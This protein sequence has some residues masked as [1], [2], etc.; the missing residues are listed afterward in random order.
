MTPLDDVGERLAA[1]WERVEGLRNQIIAV[2]DEN[3][4]CIAKVD[5]LRAKIDEDRERQRLERRADW[6]WRIIVGLTCVS[7]IISALAIYAGKL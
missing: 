4:S 3:Q 7:L 6:K 2:R 1:L 5:A